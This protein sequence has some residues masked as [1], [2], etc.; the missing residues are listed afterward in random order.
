MTCLQFRVGGRAEAGPRLLT[1]KPT[2]F[3]NERQYRGWLWGLC[4]G[5]SQT[6]WAGRGGPAPHHSS[7]LCVEW[8]VWDKVYSCHDP[9]A[10]LTNWKDSLT[11]QHEHDVMDT[12][13][14]FH[15]EVGDIFV[16]V[17]KQ[18]S[19]FKPKPTEWLFSAD[20]LHGPCYSA[21]TA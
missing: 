8:P 15:L 21:V 11:F 18:H 10:W 12:K 2:A 16:L 17:V 20:V 3:F 1:P 19:V 7:L 4:S 13:E 9:T 14:G 6:H 5:F